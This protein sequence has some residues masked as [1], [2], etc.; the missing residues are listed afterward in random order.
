MRCL[1]TAGPTREFLDP[2]RFLSNPST[3]KMGFA[4]AAA[5]VE[6]GWTVDLVAGPVGLTEP[7][8]ALLYPVVTAEE[9]Y[10]QVEALFGPADIFIATAAV[11][12]WR[13]KKRLSQKIKRSGN[14]LTLE[15]EPC[16][17][18]LAAMAAQKRPNQLLVGFAAETEKLEEH[19]R[20]K[21]ESK[22]IDWIAANSV[23]GLGGAF[24]S[25]SNTLILLGR[26]GTREVIGP[27]PK[28]EVARK[29]I[30]SLARRM[31]VR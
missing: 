1:I 29:L 16:P 9:M 23:A 8:G 18:I 14:G 31:A 12:D 30:Q 7:K 4:V 26:D 15:L 28:T 25:E 10:R 13:P 21:L 2:V 5:A 24:G 6:L 17:D 3:G 20:H 22:G 27:A 19:A 11:S